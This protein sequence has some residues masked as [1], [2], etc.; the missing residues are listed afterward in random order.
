MEVCHE[1]VEGDR[2]ENDFASDRSSVSDQ[3]VEKC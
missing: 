2:L 3:R 1:G